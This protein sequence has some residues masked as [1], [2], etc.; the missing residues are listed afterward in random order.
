MKVP[1]PQQPPF[2]QIPV[3][4]LEKPIGAGDVIANV[5]RA[6]GIKPCTPCEQRRRALNQ[7]LQFE[8][9]GSQR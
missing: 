6:I 5:T 3:P 2:L 4:R 7:L 8:P 9:K 1:V